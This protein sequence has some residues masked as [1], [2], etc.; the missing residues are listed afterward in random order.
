MS[1]T[2]PYAHETRIPCLLGVKNYL[3]NHFAMYTWLS[4][5]RIR[6]YFSSPA[7][8]GSIIIWII[9]FS[10]I[11]V[12]RASVY[13]WISHPPPTSLIS[14]VYTSDPLPYAREICFP[15]LLGKEFRNEHMSDVLPYTSR[16]C[17]PRLLGVQNYLT[18]LQSIHVWGASV[19]AC[20]SHPPPT[21]S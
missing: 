13:G 9:N 10:C 21:W 5:S 4:C 7:Y 12:W 11:H 18:I 3:N 20:N 2:L 17:I 19:C 14:Q 15:R 16:T 8:L 6:E 1:D